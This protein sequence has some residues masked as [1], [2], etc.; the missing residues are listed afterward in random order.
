MLIC[1][2]L[3]GLCV[4][5]C[6]RFGWFIVLAI[7]SLLVVTFEL[8]YRKLRILIYKNKGVWWARPRREIPRAYGVLAGA[9]IILFFESQIARFWLVATLI[10]AIVVAGAIHLHRKFEGG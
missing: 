2:L 7:Y 1:V 3:F 5:L 8:S 4:A 6:R 10:G 9:M